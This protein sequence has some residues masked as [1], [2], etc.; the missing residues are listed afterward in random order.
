MFFIYLLF[1][2]E[3]SDKAKLEHGKVKNEIDELK[4]KIT[5]GAREVKELQNQI[6]QLQQIRDTV[7]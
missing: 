4:Q 2:K 1:L 6:L 3:S 7:S 5:D